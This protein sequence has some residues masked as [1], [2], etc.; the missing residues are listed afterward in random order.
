[1]EKTKQFTIS[2][3]IHICIVWVSVCATIYLVGVQWCNVNSFAG[4]W[5]QVDFALALDR[6]D[7]MSMQPHFPGYPYFIL[8]GNFVH[9][10]IENNTASLTLLNILMYATTLIPIYKLTRICHNKAYSMCITAVAYSSTYVLVIVNQPISEGAAI[11]CLWWYVWSLYKAFNQKNHLALLAP[12]FLLGILLGIRVSYLP[13]TIGLLYLFYIKWKRD[14]LSFKQ[15]FGYLGMIAVTQSI[16]VASLIVSE[17]SIKGFIKLSLAFISG[18]FNDWG[19][20]AIASE[21]TFIDRL[22]SVM[23]DNLLWSGIS[24][25][26]VT[27]AVLYSLVFTLI[28]KD[29]LKH[30][31]DIG[32]FGHRLIYIMSCFYFIWA[33]LGQNADKPRHILPLVGFI[34]FI[35]LSSMMKRANG[36]RIMLLFILLGFHVYH[37]QNLIKQ[38]A[39]QAPATIQLADYLRNEQKNSIVYTWEETRVFQ[40]VDLPVI[41]KRIQTYEFFLQDLSNYKGKTILITD[42]AAT[43]FISQGVDISENLIKI[44]T[45][46]S[47]KLFD[48]VYSEVTLYQWKER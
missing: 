44:T 35:V 4:T 25:Q 13:F 48:P 22:K 12:I 6:F 23:I 2:R 14:R 45:F 36:W 30:R 40:Y 43:G 26:V 3:Y 32:S 10:F 41:H 39:E 7:L 11:S 18:H 24:S 27:L 21:M 38:Q 31:E 28:M 33:I 9:R 46:H 17:G 47:N 5:D 16:W 1:M 29:I 37:S 19:N 20:T 8:A 42:K 34:L 15:I